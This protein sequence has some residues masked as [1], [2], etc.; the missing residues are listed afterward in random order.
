M[1]NILVPLA[2]KNTFKIEGDSSYPKILHDIDGKL[3][4]E[5]AAAP[6]VDLQQNKKIVIAAPKEDLLGY[7][8]D[9]VLGLLGECI[10]VCHINSET[11]GAVCSALLAIEHIQLEC[12]LIITSFEQV[13]NIN[14][15]PFIERFIDSDADAGVLTFEA[16]HPKWSFVKVDISGYVTQAAEKTPISKNAIAGF[17]YFK[18]GK[19]FVES[20]KAMIRKDVTHNG[21][22]YLS[23]TLNEVILNEGRVLA[24]PIEKSD[25]FHIHDERSLE[26]YEESVLAQNN[27][28]TEKIRQLTRGYIKAFHSKDISLLAEYFADDFSLVDPAGLFS[29]KERVIEYIAGIFSSVD[30]ISFLEKQIIVEEKK[31]I[32]EFLLEIDG[33][34]LLGTDVIRW[35][36]QNKMISMHAYLYEEAN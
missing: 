8:F 26:N 34:R 6:Y 22:F 11:K 33:K 28:R 12:P 35:N 19:A 36:D 3:L 18:T 17:Y 29:G 30:N 13:L 25:Y 31:S 4:L 20:A 9:K 14:L 5:R 10:E 7:K 1:L 27:F 21:L 16:I 15:T 2:G 32:I 23:H 24:L